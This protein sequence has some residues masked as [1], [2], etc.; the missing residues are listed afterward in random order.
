MY[1][2]ISRI[3][4]LSLTLTALQ[5][6]AQTYRIDTSTISFENKLRPCYEVKYDADARTVKKAWD[7]FFKKQYRVKIKG[8]GLFTDKDIVSAEDV[9]I[10]S[11]SDKRMNLYAR[12]IDEA[13]GSDLKYFMSFGY[14]F[15]IGPE[16]YPES[17]SAMK[18]IL[19]DFSIEFLNEYYADR[20]SSITKAVKKLEKEKKSKQSSIRKNNKKARKESSTV[21]SGLEAKNTSLELEIA[22]IERK[23]QQYGQ[24]LEV[25]KIKQSGITR[26]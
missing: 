2:N 18:K 8:V 1:K 7:D 11:I 15:F 16:N 5:V 24:E 21:A 14:D 26:N 12:V 3:F 9:T 25:I 13:G 6:Q 10:G 19:N 20:A 23:I 22:E 4:F 17:F